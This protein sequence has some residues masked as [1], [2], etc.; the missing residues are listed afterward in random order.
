[1]RKNQEKCV[2]IC[3]CVVIAS[4]T[5]NVRTDKI[6][7]RNT[8]NK[9]CA[10]TGYSNLRPRVPKSK[11]MKKLQKISKTNFFQTCPGIISMHPPRALRAR[12]YLKPRFSHRFLTVSNRS[13]PVRLSLDAMSYLTSPPEPV[14]SLC[15]IYLSLDFYQ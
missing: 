8:Y 7:T 11:V 5:S 10:L 12:R 14:K 9:T 13:Q 15:M 1:M 6:P 2:V 3:R 4:P